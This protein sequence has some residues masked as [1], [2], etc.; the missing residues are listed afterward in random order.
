MPPG[1]NVYVHGAPAPTTPNANSNPNTG[2]KFINLTTE[3]YLRLAGAFISSVLTFWTSFLVLRFWLA[4][5]WYFWVVVLLSF[6]CSALVLAAFDAAFKTK[7]GLGKSIFLFI[8]LQAM[9]VLVYHYARPEKAEA[10]NKKEAPIAKPAPPQSQ[11]ITATI[12]HAGTITRSLKAGGETEWLAFEEGKIARY[13]I[14]SPSYD[15]DIYVSDNTSYPGGPNTQI[16]EKEHCYYKIKANS[17][18]FV[19]ISVEYD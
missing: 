17:D 6:I 5:T 12:L 9:L 19:T 4:P 15:Y 1:N 3:D 16:P 14:S 7:S 10:E 2:N 11:E 18:Q 13:K 8:L